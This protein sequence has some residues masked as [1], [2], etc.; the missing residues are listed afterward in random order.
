MHLSSSYYSVCVNVL[1]VTFYI[2]KTEL[3]CLRF[4]CR[5]VYNNYGNYPWRK[6]N[7]PWRSCVLCHQRSVATAVLITSTATGR[8]HL[9]FLAFIKRCDFLRHVFMIGGF[10]QNPPENLRTKMWTNFFGEKKE[11]NMKD[12]DEK[13]LIGLYFFFIPT[14][15]VL[16]FF[17][18]FWFLWL[19]LKLC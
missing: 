8:C 12:D 7:I 14:T 17:N 6:T 4:H 3:T 5:L 18:H 15:L 19:M 10:Y 11:E 13:K 16:I 1:W 2:L 9:V